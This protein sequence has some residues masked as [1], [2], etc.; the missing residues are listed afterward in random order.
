MQ[1]PEALERSG[2]GDQWL[3]EADGPQL[4]A[5]LGTLLH[6][7]PLGIGLWDAD[8]RFV[9]VNDALAEMNGLPAADHLG[10]TVTEV[11]PGVADEGLAA[12]RQVLETGEPVL[13][14]EIVGETPA[15]PG[16]E[17]SW[18]ESIYRVQLDAERVGLAAIVRETT[19]QRRGERR[20]RRLID[21]IGGFVGLL[22]P[23]GVVL[24]ANE[25]AV[26]AAG[27][28]LDEVVGQHMWDT[29]WWSHSDETRDELKAAV[30]TV[31]A[32]GRARYDAVVKL[33]DR[34]Y[35]LD[36]H[37][38]PL[39]EDGVVTAIVVSGVDVTQRRSATRRLL[40]LSD[41]S[42][43]LALADTTSAV[44]EAV[45]SHVPAAVDADFVTLALL[46]QADCSITFIHP[47]SLD[48]DLAERY[49]SMPLD[50]RSPLTDAARTGEIVIVANDAENAE[51]YPDLID[52][53][54]KVGLVAL[55]AAPLCKDDGPIGAIGFGWRRELHRDDVTEA[56]LVVIADLTAQTLERSRA[57][58]ARAGLVEELQ[59]HLVPDQPEREGLE[60][61]VRYQAAGRSIGF[62]GDWYDVVAL[63]D[64]AT[65][66][67]VGDVAGHGISAAARMAVLRTSLNAVIRLGTPLED[68]FD[69]TEPLVEHLDPDFLGT[70]LVAVV[71][72]REGTLSHTSAGH[73]PLIVKEPGTPA[74][75]LEGASRPVLGAGLRR[76]AA[77][78]EPLPP[79][80]LLVAYTDGLVEGRREH[81]DTALDRVLAV[82]DAA[83]DD[84]SCEH[85][86]DLLLDSAGSSDELTDD[87]VVVVLRVHGSDGP[88][89]S[90]GLAETDVV[91]ATFA[92]ELES[93]TDARRWAV[94][95]CR[96]WGLG[97]LGD[98]LGLVVDELVAN[99]VMH[100]GTDVEVT[101]GRAG[102]VVR[103]RVR[104]GGRGRVEA[105]PVDIE[106]IGGW[107]LH[108]VEGLTRSWAVTYDD[109]GKTV[110]F[111]IAPGSDG[112]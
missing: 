50:V 39:V 83:A 106:R 21:A 62:G 32:G 99:A 101:L 107:G 75:T 45:L 9:F 85:V 82:V 3:V 25:V 23:D 58:D 63:D 103:G 14:L 56:R 96:S 22:T 94:D 66:V 49:T 109:E 19:D 72:P 86:A 30:A 41:Y 70:A 34:Y 46:D 92:P 38:M 48:P 77:A 54:R 40:A 76:A 102:D 47:P 43:T 69:T 27:L 1:R 90:G 55:A 31:A 60:I 15:Q 67:V 111:E 78:T 98:S 68:I 44:A 73:P 20:T 97:E 89:G 11:L 88:E 51:R 87:L 24:E 2:S 110:R 52:D 4:R 91:T 53:A 18:S 36:L 74:R 81:L 17:R 65:A 108:L 5:M 26:A 7:S 61:A 79:G 57:A 80:S 93:V 33:R 42:H 10:R 13:D 37:V 112:S 16:I 8:L 28:G 35:T 12:L 6:S 64:D 84:A 104:D 59:R 71:R 29:P 105:Q 95:L 100:A